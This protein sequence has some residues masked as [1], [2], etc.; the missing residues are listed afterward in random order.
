MRLGSILAA[1]LLATALAACASRD[2]VQSL[3]LRSALVGPA[4]RGA[5]GEEAPSAEPPAPSLVVAASA[6]ASAPACPEG[7]VLV[8][9]SYCPEVEHKCQKWLDPPGKY[10]HFRCAVYE[11]PATCKSARVTLRYCI[12]KTELVEEGPLPRNHTSFHDVARVC[13]S[14]GRRPCR[15]SEWQ[16][17]CEGEEMRPYPYGWERDA[18]ACNVDIA[19]GLGKTGRL[20]DH[21]AAPGAFER[22]ASPF[23]VMDMAGNLEEW[24][25][26]DGAGKM[27]WHQV[28]KGS[29]WI[30]SRHACRSFQ[31]G[32]GPEYG[33]GETGGRCCKDAD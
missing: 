14:R 33:G 27:G 12:D 4:M 25:A 23:G 24:V 29:W 5:G 15:E 19:S 3:E 13:A 21:R 22:C 7:M 6:P 26:A 20:V 16:F 17:A 9:G 11:K 32:H 28:L 2:R 10:E 18:T 30:P 31:V 1:L 8:E